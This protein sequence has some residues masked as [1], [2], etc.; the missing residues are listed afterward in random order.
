M[1]YLLEDRRRSTLSQFLLRE[2]TDDGKNN[3]I[4]TGGNGELLKKTHSILK[5]DPNENVVIFIDT[6]P[7]NEETINTYN[8]LALYAQKCK[9]EGNLRVMVIPIV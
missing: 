4:F 6:V 8:A 5:S 3:I 7:E 9:N 2:Y 1:K